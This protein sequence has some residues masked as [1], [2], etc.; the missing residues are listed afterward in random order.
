LNWLRGPETTTISN[1]CRG[2]SANSGCTTPEQCSFSVAL[3]TI[4][5]DVTATL[6]LAPQASGQDCLSANYDDN[7]PSYVSAELAD[8]APPSFSYIQVCYRG[9]LVHDAM[10]GALGHAAM[11]EPSGVDERGGLSSIESRCM[12]ARQ[13]CMNFLR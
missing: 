12:L 13:K 4:A 1:L 11:C 10:R 9:G 5:A 8:C 6:D 7:G 3:T 2:L